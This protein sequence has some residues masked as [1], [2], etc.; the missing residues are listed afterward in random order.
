MTEP[1]YGGLT[2]AQLREAVHE[3]G[4]GEMVIKARVLEDLLNELQLLQDRREIVI[5]PLAP[6][7]GSE[8]A[9][10]STQKEQDQ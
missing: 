3:A 2:I 1:T 7:S 10:D 8:R 4:A 5:Y 9:H 6:N